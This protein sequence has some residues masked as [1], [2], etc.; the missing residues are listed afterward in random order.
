LEENEEE[1]P[2]AE[3]PTAERPKEENELMG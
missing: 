2:T 1:R 3:T